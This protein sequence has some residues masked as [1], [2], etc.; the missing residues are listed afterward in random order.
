MGDFGGG[1]IHT[2]S[3]LRGTPPY[4]GGELLA[5]NFSVVTMILRK[6]CTFH[7]EIINSIASTATTKAIVNGIPVIRLSFYCFANIIIFP[8]YYIFSTIIKIDNYETLESYSMKE[9]ALMIA[10]TRQGN[11][12]PL[13]TGVLSSP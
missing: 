11:L 8:N 7:F 5:C 6:G 9:T 3:P 13:S 4:Q 2:P 12:V 1:G 10:Y